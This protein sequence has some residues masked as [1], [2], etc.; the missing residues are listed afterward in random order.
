MDFLYLV[1]YAC[2]WLRF[3]NVETNPGLRRPDPIVCRI[4]CSN[5]RSLGGNLGDLTVSSS[6]YDIL[7]CF[8][9]LV[10]DMRHV[11]ELLVP[12]IDRL[13]LLCRG[14]MPRARGM[15]A[16]I[17]DSYGAYCKPKFEFG[18]CEMIFLR[19]VWD[20]TFMCSVFAASLT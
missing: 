17:R 8:K 14:K 9:T 7:L 5:V 10:S 2:L 11:P 6:Q 20:R 13:V 4:L 16:Y 1:F 18:C 19:Q 3:V 12:R 15:A